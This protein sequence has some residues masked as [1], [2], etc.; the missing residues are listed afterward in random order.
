[1]KKL[2]LTLGIFL[3]AIFFVNAQDVSSQ[4]KKVLNH[5]TT[6]CSLTPSQIGLV[7]PIADAMVKSRKEAQQKYAGNPS[8]LQDANNAI[9]DGFKA[10]LQDILTPEQMKKFQ[11][12]ALQRKANMKTPVVS[13]SSTVPQGNK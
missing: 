1:M 13:P 11:A 9:S 12:D 7:K 5:I 10:K 3:S 6:V 2:T 4:S 8:G